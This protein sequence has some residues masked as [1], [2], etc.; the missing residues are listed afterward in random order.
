MVQDLRA[1][2]THP[3]AIYDAMTILRTLI[4]KIT[5]QSQPQGCALTITGALGPII[6]QTAQT[7]KAPQGELVSETAILLV[8]GA[9]SRRNLSRAFC[10]V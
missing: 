6:H 8:A 10:L 4:T 2:L 3:E 1:Q 7:Q 9:H 5:L